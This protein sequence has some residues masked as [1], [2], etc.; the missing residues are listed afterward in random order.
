MSAEPDHVDDT[1]SN[2]LSD[3][4]VL[5]YQDLVKDNGTDGDLTL[6]LTAR[7]PIIIKFLF[8]ISKF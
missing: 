6:V 1:F 2:S 8:R 5:N 3:P 4:C 7:L